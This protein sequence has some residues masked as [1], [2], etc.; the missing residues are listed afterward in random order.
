MIRKT[1]DIGLASY[2]IIPLR[3]YHSKYS[4]IKNFI[5]VSLKGP[6]GHITVDL[7]ESEQLE[8]PRLGT[9]LAIRFYYL[10]LLVFGGSS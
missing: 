2:S 5:F 6:S 10:N 3:I 8:R 4:R 1:P 7:F 9:F